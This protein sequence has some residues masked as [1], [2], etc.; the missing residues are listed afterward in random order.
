MAAPATPLIMRDFHSSNATIA[1]FVVSIYILGYA[2]GPLFIAPLSEVYGRLPIY[3]VCNGQFVIWTIACA[4][5]P[6][7]GSLLFF[8]LMAGIA[9]SC[10]LTIGGGT[11]ADLIV[12]EKRGGAM[13]L[14]ALGPLLGPVIGPVAGGY[15]AE[16][17]GWRWIFWLITIAVSIHLRLEISTPPNLLT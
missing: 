10:P 16:A 13:A 3:H 5:A 2:L 15:L 7:M 6:N 12:Q 4:V 1:S 14:F 9:G 8:R 17:A 11:I